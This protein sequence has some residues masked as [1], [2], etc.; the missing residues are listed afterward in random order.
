MSL[1]EIIEKSKSL[2]IFQS[3]C[4]DDEY[5][6]IVILNAQIDKWDRILNEIFGPAVKPAGAKPTKDLLHLTKEFGGIH[7]DQVLFKKKFQDSTVLAMLWPWQDKTHTTLKMA[8][9]K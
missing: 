5:V 3:R 9:I 2:N 6:E 8:V 7:D 1:K 4:V